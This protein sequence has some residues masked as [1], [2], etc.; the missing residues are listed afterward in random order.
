MDYFEIC[1]LMKALIPIEAVFPTRTYF[2]PSDDGDA[3]V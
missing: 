3:H 1:C 2:I